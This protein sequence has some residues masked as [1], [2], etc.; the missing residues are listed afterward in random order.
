MAFII[1]YF[2]KFLLKLNINFINYFILVI[3]QYNF[4]IN[5]LQIKHQIRMNTALFTNI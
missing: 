4:L 1:I 2:F 5:L 3:L